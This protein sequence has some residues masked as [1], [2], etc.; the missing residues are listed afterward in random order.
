[1]SSECYD[2][3]DCFIFLTSHSQLLDSWHIQTNYE[4]QVDQKYREREREREKN[5]KKEIKFCISSNHK[6]F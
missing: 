4:S 3:L 6:G 2:M 5:K 1:M